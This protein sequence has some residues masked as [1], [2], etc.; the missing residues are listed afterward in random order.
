MRI[1][2]VLSLLGQ[3]LVL[4][5]AFFFAWYQTL[6]WL[7]PLLA[8]LLDPVL[9]LVWPTSFVKVQA[10]GASLLVLTRAVGE[11]AATGQPNQGVA[12]NPFTYSYSIPLFA[13]LA[14]ASD[15]TWRQHRTR[16]ALGLVVLIAGVCLSILASL[17]FSFQFEK[18]FQRLELFGSPAATDTLVRYLH[19]LGFQLLPRVLPILL[20]LLLYR[21][22]LGELIGPGGKEGAPAGPRRLTPAE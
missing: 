17:L 7:V 10:S 8:D 15:A 6:V 14:I 16:L 19:F 20:W 5:P 3:V 21:E 4:L 1:R 13:A 18:G 22:W 9:R 12:L 11:A 2:P